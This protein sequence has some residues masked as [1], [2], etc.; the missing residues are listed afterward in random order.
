LLAGWGYWKVWIRV[1][2]SALAGLAA[3]AVLCAVTLDAVPGLPNPRPFWSRTAKRLSTLS[4]PAL[5]TPV[6]DALYS[7]GD[8]DARSNREVAEWL[9]EN[10]PEDSTL[11]VWGF[12]P[13]IYALSRRRPASRYVDDVP[14][15]AAWAKEKSRRILIG[16]LMASPPAAIVVVHGDR[17]PWVTGNRQD[18]FESLRDFPELLAMLQHQYRLATRFGDLEIRLRNDL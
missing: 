12:E 9:R 13:A 4:Q 5:R 2:G 16:E 8:V 15:R 17:L 18:S 10:T 6:R 1:R 7:L 3:A 14:Q 11:F